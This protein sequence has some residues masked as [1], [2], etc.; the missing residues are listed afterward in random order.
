VPPTPQP[1]FLPALDAVLKG[2]TLWKSG[3]V[4]EN[5]K[6]PKAFVQWPITA[7]AGVYNIELD[8]S[9]LAGSR[10]FLVEID[11]KTLSGTVSA[12][13]SWWK[14]TKTS[15]GPVTLSGGDMILRVKAPPGTSLDDALMHLRSVC[16]L[17]P[18]MTA[19]DPL[20]ASIVLLP[21]AAELH[22]THIKLNDD[23]EPKIA[24]WTSA[25]DWAEWS[26]RQTYQKRYRVRIT[27]SNAD[28][29]GGDFDMMVNKEKIACHAGST[30]SFD[31]PRTVEL[32]FITL[33][34][35]RVTIQIKPAG[36]FHYAL[37]NLWKV[38]F[39]PE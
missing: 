29:T 2:Q 24:S 10:P 17:P 19:H 26:I 36:E 4:I 28:T 1:I 35:G 18:G 21:A 32:G 30:G 9:L 16:L 6:D 7:A 11:G 27:L 39:S 22:G 15:I 5:W 8:Y 31:T 13:G 37:M 12:T 3:G 38:E 23:P 25:D 14:F 20:A 34:A 33:P